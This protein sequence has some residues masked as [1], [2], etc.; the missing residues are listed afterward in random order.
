MTFF[1]IGPG[2]SL[3]LPYQARQRSWRANI[4]RVDIRDDMENFMS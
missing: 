1:H 2:I 3:R 4:G